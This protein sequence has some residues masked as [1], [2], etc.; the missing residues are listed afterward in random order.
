MYLQRASDPFG[1]TKIVLFWTKYHG[2]PS[3]DFGLGSRP[4]EQAGC[5]YSNCKTTTD[6]LLLNESHALIFHSGNLNESDIP[7]FRYDH[8]KWIF[9]TFTSPVNMAPLPKSLNVITK[10]NLISRKHEKNKKINKR[11]SYRNSEISKNKTI[12]F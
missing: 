7:S 6:R 12:Y 8:Q 1:E 11:Q 9:Y 3:F 4:F 10:Q 5:K 2:S